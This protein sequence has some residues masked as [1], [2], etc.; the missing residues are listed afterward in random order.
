MRIASEF[1]AADAKLSLIAL[2]CYALANYVLHSFSL[3]PC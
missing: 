1:V 3:L 2:K